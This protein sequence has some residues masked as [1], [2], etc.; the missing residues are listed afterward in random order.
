[1][2]VLDWPSI[3]VHSPVGLVYGLVR[4]VYGNIQ[5]TTLTNGYIQFHQDFEC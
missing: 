4:L 1:M 2:Q 3:V 5:V